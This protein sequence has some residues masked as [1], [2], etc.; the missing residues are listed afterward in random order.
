MRNTAIAAHSVIG[1]EVPVRSISRWTF[2]SMHARA[3]GKPMRRLGGDTLVRPNNFVG[4]VMPLVQ[5]AAN[6]DY[7]AVDLYA[8][9]F[10]A[11]SRSFVSMSPRSGM[12]RISK[13]TALPMN[14]S[15]GI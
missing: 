14:M 12:C 4:R 13:H 15:S 7:V 2:D 5:P 1:K 10:S 3:V 11:S 6:Q 9:F 8:G